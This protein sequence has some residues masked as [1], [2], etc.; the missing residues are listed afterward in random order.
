[1]V[2][3]SQVGTGVGAGSVGLLTAE[4]VQQ[5]AERGV[6]TQRQADWAAVGVSGI[7]LWAAVFG[8]LGYLPIGGHAA[9]GLGGFGTGTAVWYAG[10]RTGVAP[11][12]VATTPDTV[13]LTGPLISAAVFTSVGIGV[14]TLSGLLR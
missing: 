3:S 9:L 6:L 13:N 11:R 1:M 7:P 5:S 8:E 14:A 12:L 10:R 4:G 2:T